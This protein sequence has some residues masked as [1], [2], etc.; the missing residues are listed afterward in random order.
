M[1]NAVPLLLRERPIA[2]LAAARD[3]HFLSILRDGSASDGHADFFQFFDD[4]FVA[5][6]NNILI[7]GMSDGDSPEPIVMRLD[8]TGAVDTNAVGAT[9]AGS[10]SG[11][12]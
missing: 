11:S 1:K 3:P 10:A 2:S 5:V 4:V 12:D 8:D 9:G 6:D 7:S